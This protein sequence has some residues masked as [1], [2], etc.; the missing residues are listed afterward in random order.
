M[1]DGIIVGTRYGRNIVISLSPLGSMSSGRCI[2]TDASAVSTIG[3]GVS[4][5]TVGH[6][7][8]G[9]GGGGGTI[10]LG[11]IVNDND[12]LGGLTTIEFFPIDWAVS[13]PLS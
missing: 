3:V 13:S 7:L 4:C 2:G 1:V 11:G 10:G 9:R 12:L 5:A 6:G 8:C